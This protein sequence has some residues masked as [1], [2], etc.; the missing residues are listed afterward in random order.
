VLGEREAKVDLPLDGL[1][2]G[3][4]VGVLGLNLFLLDGATVGVALE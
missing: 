4:I 2:V 3:T 1:L